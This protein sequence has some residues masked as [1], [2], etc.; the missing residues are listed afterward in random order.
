MDS[1][2]EY[3]M[4]LNIYF[5]CH[6][7]SHFKEKYLSVGLEYLQAWGKR[8]IL[9]GQTLMEKTVIAFVRKFVVE[10]GLRVQVAQEINVVPF[11]EKNFVKYEALEIP[12]TQ[13]DVVSEGKICGPCSITNLIDRLKLRGGVSDQKDLRNKLGELGFGRKKKNYEER[14]RSIDISSFS[15]DDMFFSGFDIGWNFLIKFKPGKSGPLLYKDELRLGKQDVNEACI[16]FKSLIGREPKK[17]KGSFFFSYSWVWDE[18]LRSS[19]DAISLEK[20]VIKYSELLSKQPIYVGPGFLDYIMK[21]VPESPLLTVHDFFSIPVLI[22]QVL[23]YYVLSVGSGS[24]CELERYIIDLVQGFES[25]PVLR[26]LLIGVVKSFELMRVD[27]LYLYKVYARDSL[28][29]YPVDEKLQSFTH[30]TLFLDIKGSFECYYFRLLGLLL[31]KKGLR[32]KG[33]YHKAFYSD[34][35]IFGNDGPGYVKIGEYSTYNTDFDRQSLVFKEFKVFGGRIPRHFRVKN[36]VFCATFESQRF[37]LFE[38]SNSFISMITKRFVLDALRLIK[39]FDLGYDAYCDPGG[40]SIDTT[41]KPRFNDSCRGYVDWLVLNSS[42]GR[43]ATDESFNRWLELYM[44]SFWE[45]T[46]FERYCGDDSSESG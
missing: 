3:F 8:K 14:N 11:E 38:E 17:K 28:V 26:E 13:Q 7:D 22:N 31:D 41:S 5:S 10:A 2:K 25:P 35:V 40:S 19:D 42:L 4:D 6:S 44:Y 34:S 29:D 32:N 46:W 9:R 30:R 36:A 45:G 20:F 39:K 12:L 43:T 1:S 24:L 37:S 18:Y 15:A 27:S 23:S 21:D 16:K 33:K